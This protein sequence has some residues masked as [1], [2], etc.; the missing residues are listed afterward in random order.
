MKRLL[1]YVVILLACFGVFALPP[2]GGV[3]VTA[4]DGQTTFRVTNGRGRIVSVADSL[5]MDSVEVSLL[6]CS[7]GT[8]AYQLYGHTALRVKDCPRRAD[9]VFNYG[10]FD[11]RVSHFVWRFILGECDYWV[12]CFPY[13]YFVEDYGNRGSSVTEQ[14]LD[15]TA[16]EKLRLYVGLVQNTQP[17]NKT[18]RYNFLTNNCTTKARDMIE[19][20]VEGRLVYEEADEHVTYRQLL[21]HCTQAYPWSEQGNDILLGADCDTLLSDRA[22]QFLPEQLMRY[23][24][25][26]QI[27]DSLNNRR[28]LIRETRV[29]LEARPQ[30]NA[31]RRKGYVA[32]LATPTG[33]SA[34]LL[35]L[36][37]FIILV[38]YRT[39]RMWWV[40]DALS[41][42]LQGIAGTL[43]C[44][45]FFF[46]L[47]PTMDSNWQVWVFNPLPLLFMP[48]VVRCAIKGKVCLYHYFNMLWLTLFLVFSL[49]IPQDFSTMTLPLALALLLRSVSYYLHYIQK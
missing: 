13:S 18:Y 23:L 36:F 12:D 31:E 37:L 29:L 16:E 45:M 17:E 20:A 15:L 46:S 7:P 6:T 30:A 38:E 4:S 1:A 2:V 49:W 28:P 44:F 10:V 24:E 48:W 25:T 34:V 11:F 32:R 41:M 9:L 35:L 39:Q 3:P 47:H 8:E 14:V 27:Y 40:I 26:A 33:I 5:G 19:R 43:L 22:A 21:H 42:T